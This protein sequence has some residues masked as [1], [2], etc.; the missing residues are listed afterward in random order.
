[1]MML[2]I[3]CEISVLASQYIKLQYFV[4]NLRTLIIN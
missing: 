3:A 1:M 2:K 4:E